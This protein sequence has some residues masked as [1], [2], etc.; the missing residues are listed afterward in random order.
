MSKNT[1]LKITCSNLW[2][3]NIGLNLHI[4]IQHLIRN[5]N[6]NIHIVVDS[7]CDNHTLNILKKD[8]KLELAQ[9]NIGGNFFKNRQLFGHDSKTVNHIKLIPSP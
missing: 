3:L 2:G 5:L 7:H 1:K 6:M 9:F 8:Y 4:K